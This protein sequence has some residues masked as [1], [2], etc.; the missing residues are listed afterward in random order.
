MGYLQKLS[1]GR[2]TYDKQPAVTV[3]GYDGHAREDWDAVGARLREAAAAH[4]APRIV[5]AI[6]TV[7]FL[8]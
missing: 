6:E 7:N 3:A 5:V 2:T 1:L 4:P 8:R